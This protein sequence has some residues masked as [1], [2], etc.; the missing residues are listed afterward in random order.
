MTEVAGPGALYIDPRDEAAAAETIAAKL[1]G[2]GS[3][4]DAGFENAKRFQPEV[5]FASYEGFFRGVLRTRR[6]TDVVVAAN[7]AETAAG[8]SREG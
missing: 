8:Q 2:I 3:L 6:I 5:V 4:R 1:D 7:E